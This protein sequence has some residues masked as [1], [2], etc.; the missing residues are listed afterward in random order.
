MKRSIEHRARMSASHR[1]KIGTPEWFAAYEEFIANN[2]AVKKRPSKRI[3]RA[4]SIF[5]SYHAPNM[6]GTE[7]WAS[8]YSN[9]IERQLLIDKAKRLKLLTQKI[10]VND[11]LF[12]NV[13]NSYNEYEQPEIKII[14]SIKY[15][16]GNCKECGNKVF[17]AQ[18][19]QLQG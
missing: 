9:Y 19:E 8:L 12:C 13:C 5:A 4:A 16:V 2:G 1:H 10:R 7:I 14:D 11:R 6:R 15:V 18:L 17:P 3:E